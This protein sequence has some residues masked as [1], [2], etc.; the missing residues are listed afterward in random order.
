MKILR[1]IAGKTLCDRETNGNIRRICEVENVNTWVK[2]RK[3]EWNQ[4]INRMTE[5]RIVKIA[6]DKSPGGRR[7]IG[8]PRKRWND[9]L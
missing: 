1:K 6:R 7:S 8:R 9:D 5:Q 4:H 2:N 3:Q